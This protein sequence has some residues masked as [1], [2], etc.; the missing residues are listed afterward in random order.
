[1]KQSKD[2]HFLAKI[3]EIHTLHLTDTNTMGTISIRS[4]KS[5]YT[6]QLTDVKT[7]ASHPTIY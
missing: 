1:M 5:Q 4:M 7:C 6:L 3:P 2:R